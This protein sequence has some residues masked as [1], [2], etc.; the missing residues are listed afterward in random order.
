MR[1]YQIDYELERGDDIYNLTIEAI[2]YPY[3][4]GVK[5]L[6][7]EYSY[8]DE[9]GE[10]EITAINLNGTPWDGML[11]DKEIEEVEQ[12]VFHHAQQEEDP[13]EAPFDDR[14]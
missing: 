12:W 14:F 8:P 6:A 11:G 13:D 4:R 2:I 1:K 10:I 5:H 9:G 7:P 3:K